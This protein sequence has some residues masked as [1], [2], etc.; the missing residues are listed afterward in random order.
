MLE[1]RTED[2]YSTILPVVNRW[3]S[4]VIT[5]LYLRCVIPAKTGMQC[6]GCGAACV[7]WIPAFAGMTE[8]ARMATDLDKTER[9]PKFFIDM[10]LGIG[11]YLQRLFREKWR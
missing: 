1:F 3:L 11:Q 4:T 8:R 7:F 10:A 2:H 6:G 9:G 5:Q